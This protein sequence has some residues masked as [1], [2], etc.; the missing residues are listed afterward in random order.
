MLTMM[1][2]HR[3]GVDVR[4]ES[5]EA[6]RKVGQFKSHC[7]VS[8]LVR[9]GCSFAALAPPADDRRQH[10]DEHHYEDEYLD[11]LVDAGN[12]SAEEIPGEQHAPYPDDRPDYADDEELPVGHLAYTGN[13]R[14]ERAND[15]HELGEDDGLPPMARVK[16][17]RAEHML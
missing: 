15:R 13:H 5:I 12:I 17:L 3:R 7:S 10:G 9:H 14:R 2:L 8:W 1:D 6:I 16:L 11:V 4:L